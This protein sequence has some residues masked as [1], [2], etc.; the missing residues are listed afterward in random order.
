MSMHV[1]GAPFHFQAEELFSPIFATSLRQTTLIVP[2]GGCDY[3]RG[4]KG[5]VCAFCAFPAAT[6]AAVL[7]EGAEGRF[8]PW[9]LDAD[10]Y[11]EMFERMLAGNEAIERVAIFN[12]GSF[13]HESEIPQAAQDHVARWYGRAATCREL[14]VEARPDHVTDARLARLGALAA[15][16]P[17]TIGLGFET[18][19]ARLRNKVLR[20]GISLARFE[21]AVSTIRRHGGRA[22]A[23]AFLKPPGLTERAAFE[24]TLTTLDYLRGVGVDQMALSSAFVPP[25]AALER[26]YREGAFQP[27]WLWTIVEI[28]RRARRLGHPLS[29]GGLEDYPPPIASAANCGRCDAEV[30][31]AIDQHRRTGDLAPFDGL[32]CACHERWRG[33]VAHAA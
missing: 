19:D 25:G 29:I 28:A 32:A 13:L 17:I 24:E 22:F 8:E 30:R 1:R 23:Y 6:R 16:K 20:K 14:F 26:L 3:W 5:E 21:Q 10:V 18:L 9:T 2:G 12:G 31:A 4:A 11:I 7:G 15:G 33:E 27:P